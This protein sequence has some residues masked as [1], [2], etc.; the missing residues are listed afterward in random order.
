MRTFRS[1]S[2]SLLWSASGCFDLTRLDG[3]GFGEGWP[4]FAGERSCFGSGFEGLV[5]FDLADVDFFFA[6]VL[7][8]STSSSV[9]LG[10]DMLWMKNTDVIKTG[11]QS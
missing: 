10:L 3:P 1:S 7:D 2:I 8:A 5:A 11:F 9:A 4:A 6:D